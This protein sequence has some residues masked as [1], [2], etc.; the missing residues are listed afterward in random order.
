MSVNTP[1]PED[2]WLN[3]AVLKWAREWRGR[4]LEEAAN[5]AKKDVRVIEAWESGEKTP[6][7]KQARDLAAYYDRPF[8]EFLLPEP[9]ELP[10]PTSLPDFRMHRDVQPP[11]NDWDLQAELRWVESQRTNALDLYDEIGET[12]PEF[13]AE[14][15]ASL[16]D[17]AERKADLTRSILQ[18]PIERQVQLTRTEAGRLP[19]LL[20]GLIESV[21]VLTLRRT[22][23]ASLKV[24]GICIAD[25]PLPAIV[26]TSETPTAQAFS[27]MHEFGHVLL[28]Q[29]GVSGASDR[30]ADTGTVEGWCNR[31]AA[32]FLIP[33]PY[34]AILAGSVPQHPAPTIE[35][36]VL[37]SYAKTLRVS[38][39][40]MLIRLVQL[41]YVERSYYWDVKKPEYDRQEAVKQGGGKPE[42]YGVRYRSMQG[43]LYT[44]LV[45]E[46]WGLGRIT[47][48]KAGE[49]MR[50]KNMSHLEDIRRHFGG[51]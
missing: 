29:S 7:V 48:H 40:A 33:A 4:T 6:T 50:I 13:P 47:N 36:S 27:L 34:A 20:R 10:R 37:A 12:P 9:P 24:R 51:A 41:G 25:F 18:F 39:H 5:K 44:G 2:R 32:A 26:F 17:S 30:T 46:A 38:P 31:F 21:G 43:D 49:F 42:Y 16:K 15:F 14:L 35:D 8:L 11:S 23:L 28:K 19:G 1:I 22:S 3:P 45:L